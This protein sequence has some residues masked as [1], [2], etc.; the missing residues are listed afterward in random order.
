VWD[1]ND[2]IVDWNEIRSLRNIPLFFKGAVPFGHQGV[3]RPVRSVLYALSY[4]LWGLN[5]SGYHFQAILA[6][7][8]CTLLIYFIVSEI[9]KKNLIAFMSALIFGVHPIHTEAVTLITASFDTIGIA[10]FL[11]SFYLYLKSQS[12]QGKTNKLAIASVIL[13]LFAFFTYELTLTLPLLIVLYDLC[14]KKIE[15]NNMSKSL[16]AYSPYFIGLLFYIFVRFFILDITSRGTYLAGSFYLTMLTMTKSFLKYFL[17]TLFPINLNVN[18]RISEGILSLVHADL[19][20]QAI[21]AQSIFNLNILFSIIVLIGLLIIA[22]KSFK[23]YP[24]ISFCIGWF[25]IG[26]APVSNIIPRIALLAEKY[27]YIPSFG[28]CLLLSSLIYNS[29]RL[30]PDKYKKHIKTVLT[31]LFVFIILSYSTLTISRNADWKDEFTIWSKTAE[32]TPGSS[33]AHNN[34]G[35]AYLA[36]GERDLAV[37]EYNRAIELNSNYAEAYVNI[38]NIY[39]Q[40]KEFDLAIEEFKKAIQAKPTLA[41]AHNNL[42]NAYNEKKQ[43]DLAIEEYKKAIQ[44]NPNYVRAHNHLGAAY[45][46]KGETDLAIDSYKKTLEINPNHAKTHNNLG[47]LYSAKGKT[48]L[49]IEEFKKAIQINPDY[50]KAKENLA[51][52][53]R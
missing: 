42:G 8:T 23:K 34:L 28:L 46:K 12:N 43:F 52:I 18:H 11:A 39:I 33:L 40:E 47:V 14:F 32:Q 2:F 16:K 19:N 44:I 45:A 49:A 21:L 41:E 48:D 20:E 13:A 30:S 17:I 31:L 27:T 15:K 1:D 6:H 35:L 50:T 22:V 24:I 37:K 38:G 25:F 7:L 36:R 10:L 51:K 4:K 53:Y 29:F 9:T 3:Y 26:L 5:P